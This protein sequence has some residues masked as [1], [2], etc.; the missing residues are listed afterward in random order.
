MLVVVWE[1]MYGAIP[2]LQ[3]EEQL[4]AYAVAVTASPAQDR[5][6]VRYRESVL[7]GWRKQMQ[8]AFARVRDTARRVSFGQL[9]DVLRGAFEE[10]V[11]E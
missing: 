9:R 2:R 1:A 11:R 8:G 10:Q 4:A 6:G 7:D 3:A 5:Q